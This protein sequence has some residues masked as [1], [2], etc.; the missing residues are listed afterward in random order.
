MEH[1][2]RFT[3]EELHG[4]RTSSLHLFIRPLNTLNMREDFLHYIWKTGQWD[5][6]CLKTTDG[7]PISILQKGRHNDLAGPD[8]L[9]AIV[10]IEGARWAGS[11][12]IHLR[13]SDWLKHKHSGDP[14]Y[15]NV[16][17]HVVWEEDT[18]ILREDGTEIPCIALRNRISKRAVNTYHKLMLSSDWVPCA[19]GLAQVTPL[20]MRSWM[21]RLMVERLEARKI[22]F[23]LLKEA[24]NN[25][26][27]RIFFTV[28]FRNFG[29]GVNH[30]AFD[31]IARHL[32]YRI[33]L[34]HRN[35]RTDIESLLFGMAGF[36]EYPEIPDDYTL[37]LYRRFSHW[38]KKYGLIPR[39]KNHMHFFKLRP[40]NFPTI[41]LAQ[42]AYFMHKHDNPVSSI[43]EFTMEDEF[44]KLFDIRV[45]DYWQHHYNFGKA[46]KRAISGKLSPGTIRLLLINTIIPF[47]YY[48]GVDTGRQKYLNRAMRIAQALPP[49]H[50]HI[51]RKWRANGVLPESALDSQALLQLKRYYCDAKRCMQ[52]AVGHGIIRS[53]EAVH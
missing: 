3:L 39:N 45:S 48:Y 4:G 16:I 21:D 9:E 19:F 42:L 53:E 27:A 36:L 25:D 12:E 35:E 1:G 30:K 8:F 51:I 47:L 2:A 6:S 14:L 24:Y 17:L 26:T 10:E 11:V 49:E 38:K 7:R 40:P 20:R 46:R 41:R 23:Q 5:I 28:L 52:C 15:H 22:Q 43:L 32:D 44:K 31:E 13:A 18:R 37:D 33:I 34:K 50:N 29:F